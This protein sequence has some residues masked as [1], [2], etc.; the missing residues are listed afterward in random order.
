MTR[1]EAI[2]IYVNSAYVHEGGWNMPVIFKDQNA[3]LALE[4][5][6]LSREEELLL[7][8]NKELVLKELDQ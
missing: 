3:M 7:L 1:A 2:R 5:L 4:I 6:K 8:R